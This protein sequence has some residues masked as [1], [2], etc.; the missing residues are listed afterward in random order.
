M[1][2]WPPGLI[3]RLSRLEILISLLTSLGLLGDIKVLVDDRDKHLQYD[4]WPLGSETGSP[5]FSNLGGWKEYSTICKKEK[6]HKKQDDDHGLTQVHFRHS[7]RIQ[8]T[9]PIL[10]RK[11]LIDGQERR[12]DLAKVQRRDSR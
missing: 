6:A 8:D 1:D 7:R 11:D 5:T 2:P 9:G 4:D 10:R 3:R 12:E